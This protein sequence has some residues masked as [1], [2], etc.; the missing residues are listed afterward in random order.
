[1]DNQN[2]SVSQS[3]SSQEVNTQQQPTENKQHSFLKRKHFII[4]LT[5][6]ILSTIVYV[7]IYLRL[8]QITKSNQVPQ[9]LPSPTPTP[10]PTSNW[11]TYTELNTGF[12]MKYPNKWNQLVLKDNTGVYLTNVALSPESPNFLEKHKSTFE[13]FGESPN[14]ITI[15]VLNIRDCKNSSD[16]AQQ[17]LNKYISL[18]DELYPGL[19]I[20][21]LNLTNIYGYI[22]YKGAPGVE[23]QRGPE[24][25]IF[26]CPKEIQ[27]SFDPTGI[28]NSNQ[29]FSQIL[30]T[31]KFTDENTISWESAVEIIK[32]CQV[33]IVTQTHSKN[34]G[35]IL[36]DGTSK[37]TVEPEIDMVIEEAQ[38]ASA[39]CGFNIDVLTE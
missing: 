32:S 6:L 9:I 33:K 24:I 11:K 38:D 14:G 36:K 39:K 4:I 17:E 29:L 13:E 21:S 30:S 23:A 2:Q 31:F 15:K 20:S 8:D 37:N 27:I 10:D 22:I 5:V 18:K 28:E 35:I 16:Y 34:V 26:H 7:G 19:E 3:S 25:F 1:M 12:V